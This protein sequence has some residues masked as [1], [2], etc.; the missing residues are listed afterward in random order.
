[1]EWC[2]NGKADKGYEIRTAKAEIEDLT[3][4][5]SKAT[6]DIDAS[7]TKLEELAA[8]ISQDEADLKAATEIRAKEREEFEAAESELVEAVD[9]L[10]R[11]INILERKMK[12]SA[13][14]MQ[15]K[16]NSKDL[17]SMLNA[18]N[19][20]VEAASLSLHDKKKLVAL[21]QSQSDSDSDDED[22]APGAPDAEVY[23]SKSGSIIDVLEDMREKAQGQLA[24]ARKEETTAKHNFEMLKQSLEDQIAA[25]SKELAEAKASK[26]GAQETKAVAEGDLS[27]TKKDLADDEES[28]ENLESDCKAKAEDHETSTA[29]RAEELKAL[30]EAKKVISGMTGAA[31]GRVYSFLQLDGERSSMQSSISTR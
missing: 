6:V 16:Y 31:E 12:G 1:M 4:T 24:E 25:D 27:V 14:L 17:R 20:V 28:L 22:D 26:A 13:S 11:A 8:S 18:L 15:A 3:A 2:K 23:K 10:D 9:M 5:I 7:S 30:A 21:A 29:G 19:T